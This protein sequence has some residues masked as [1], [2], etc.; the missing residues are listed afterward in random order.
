MTHKIGCISYATDQGLGI[1]MKDFYDAGV[2]TDPLI[3]RH[4]SRT[5]HTEWYPDDTPVV[6][7]RTLTVE[8]SLNPVDN[9]LKRI[10]TLLVFETPFDWRIIAK[11][12][13][14]NVRT[15][16]VPMYECMPTTL[17]EVP[18]VIA[19]PSTLDL[20]YYKEDPR[21][22]SRSLLMP[23]PVNSLVEYEPRGS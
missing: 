20:K 8:S 15:V 22:Q 12:R 6:N 5:T 3:V 1:L 23:I 19:C 18:D 2:V 9:F 14:Y 7:A 17:P 11:C 16:L 21:Y 13:R 4:S 10:D